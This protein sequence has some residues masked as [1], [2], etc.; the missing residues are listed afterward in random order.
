MAYDTELAERIRELVAPLRGVEEKPMFGG[1]AFLINGNMSIAAS[2]QGG[3]LVRVP[4][5]DA[6][7]LLARE[8]VSPM[9]MRGREVRGW[10]RVDAEAVKTKRQLQSWVT[11][12]TDYARGLPPK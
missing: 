12:S 3:L 7:K 11:R 6:D 9:V 8:H 2:G 4:A 1:L 10:L 5:E